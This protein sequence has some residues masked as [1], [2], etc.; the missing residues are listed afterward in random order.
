M[1]TLFA[2]ITAVATTT[3]SISQTLRLE[4]LQ[5]T[6][7][8]VDYENA[9]YYNHGD[10]LPHIDF[11]NVKWDRVIQK[12]HQA[13]VLESEFVTITV[14]PQMGRVYSMIYRPT[15]HETLW[16]NDIVR[17]GGANNETGWWLWIG[18]IE[19]TLPKDEHGTSWALKWDYEILTDTETCKTLRMQVK[20]PT[21][22][23]YHRVDLS[24]GA[25]S[26]AMKS[27]I[28]IWNPTRGTVNFAHWTNPMWVPGGH[29]QLT[30]HTEF[31][32]PTK[33]ILIEE[34]WQ[35][36]LGPSPQSWIENPLRYIR[37]WPEMGDLM[38][39]GL[40]AGF[41]GVYSH[42]EEEGVVRVFDPLLNPGVDYVDL[43][44]QSGRYSHGIWEV[45]QRICRNLGRYS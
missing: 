3:I 14:L 5:L 38:A 27:D 43:R 6:I 19:Y 30:D 1:R 39:D 29:N 2:L 4:E 26:S 13:V 41:Y 9:I 33:Q 21:S 34:R 16:Q 22:G 18:G 42:D 44:L 20:E 40:D 17:P 11:K 8:Q 7:P 12:E 28:R 23:L 32:I 15:G 25:D 24:L 31:I 45:E 37:N 35:K 36:N 10:P